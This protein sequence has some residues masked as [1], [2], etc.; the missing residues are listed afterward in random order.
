MRKAFADQSGADGGLF[1]VG[2]W[3][4]LAFR[5][6]VLA[7]DRQ[8]PVVFLCQYGQRCEGRAC[9]DPR[10]FAIG[11]IVALVT[12]VI[13]RNIGGFLDVGSPRRIDMQADASFGDQGRFTLHHHHWRCRCCIVGARAGLG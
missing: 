12:W 9:I 7:G 1:L 4:I 2:L 8:L 5:P 13:V 10:R 11:I 3:V 6:S